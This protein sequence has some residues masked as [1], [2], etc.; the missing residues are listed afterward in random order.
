MIVIRFAEMNL[1]KHR[2]KKLNDG[3]TRLRFARLELTGRLPSRPRRPSTA[4]GWARVARPPPAV[5][6]RLDRAI[7]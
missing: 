4:K 6:A 2:G 7:Q 5:I 1:R 3:V